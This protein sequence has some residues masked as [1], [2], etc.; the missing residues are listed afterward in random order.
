MRSFLARSRWL[1]RT[2]RRWRCLRR[3][4]LRVRSPN[5]HLEQLA[6]V[7]YEDLSLVE[8]VDLTK[9]FRL[10]SA[11]NVDSFFLDFLSV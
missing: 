8:G 2:I 7:A 5:V 9:R 6:G 11:N 3:L 4:D 1:D 10:N